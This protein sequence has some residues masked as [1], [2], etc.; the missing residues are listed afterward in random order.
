MYETI[1]VSLLLADQKRLKSNG[2]T[3]SFYKIKD[4]KKMFP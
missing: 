1:F 4:S 3:P 2:R